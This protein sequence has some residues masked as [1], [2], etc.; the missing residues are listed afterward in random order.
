MVAILGLPATFVADLF[1]SRHRLEAEILCLRPQLNIALKDRIRD[2]LHLRYLFY[3]CP[4]E[5]RPYCSVDDDIGI[6]C[7]T[8]QVTRESKAVSAEGKPL[9]GAT[10]KSLVLKCKKDACEAKAVDSNGKPLNGAAKNRFIKKCG[11]HS[12]LGRCGDAMGGNEAC[13]SRT[14]RG[15]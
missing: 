12:S 7:A 9:A 1:K 3:G 5:I 6:G 15:P 14:K 4:D 2:K 8:A 10:K 11:K 13:S